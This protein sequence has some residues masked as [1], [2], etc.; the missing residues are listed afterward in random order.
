MVDLDA[1]AEIYCEMMDRGR[2]ARAEAVL[3]R[4]LVE[5]AGRLPP[6]E[7]AAAIMAVQDVRGLAPAGTPE[8]RRAALMAR[9]VPAGTDGGQ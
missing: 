9:L 1:F 8:A 6:A 5:M 7:L 2:A 3:P 4:L